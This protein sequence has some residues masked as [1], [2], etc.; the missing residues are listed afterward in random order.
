MD[1]V[2]LSRRNLLTLLSKLDRHEAGELTTCMI[3][4][5]QDPGATQTQSMPAIAV[6][7]LSDDVAYPHRQAGAMVPEDEVNTTVPATGVAEEPEPE[8]LA[9]LYLDEVVAAKMKGVYE[10]FEKK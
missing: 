2:Y 3:I 8:S 9:F 4:K 5:K 7:A 10:A 1:V 6:V